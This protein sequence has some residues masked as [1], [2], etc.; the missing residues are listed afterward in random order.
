MEYIP[1]LEDLKWIQKTNILNASVNT[2]N[3]AANLHQTLQLIFKASTLSASAMQNAK[4]IT[5][6]R[7]KFLKKI[8]KELKY[9]LGNTTYQNSVRNIPLIKQIRSLS[10]SENTIIA[11][12][13]K[14]N[15]R[16]EI[17]LNKTIINIQKLGLTLVR[18]GI[19]G[20]TGT[21]RE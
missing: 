9:S 14:M 13:V 17:E 7:N 16:I 19:I 4:S 18:S 3:L 12:Y 15:E 10:Y 6:R 21:V 2:H 1:T 20:S 11:N 5:R 8:N